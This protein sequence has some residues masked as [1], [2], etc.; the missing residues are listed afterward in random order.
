[1]KKVLQFIALGVMSMI[2]VSCLSNEKRAAKLIKK[3]LSKTLYDFES[4]EPIETIVTEAK[5]T[6]YNDSAC[7]T[8]AAVI[9][10]HM[11]DVFEYLEEAKN[12]EEEM[13][14]WGPHHITHRHIATINTIDIKKSMMRT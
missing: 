3:E 2:M 9:A 12:A 10:Y 7:W 11:K 6:M 5:M 14:I 4:Y 13:D 8:K 1:M